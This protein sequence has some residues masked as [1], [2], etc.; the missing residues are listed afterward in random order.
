MAHAVEAA[1]D[2]MTDY[3]EIPIAPK[4]YLSDVVCIGV[5]ERPATIPRWVPPLS[6][7][8][9]E[10][11][12]RVRRVKKE[13]KIAGREDTVVALKEINLCEGSEMFPVHRGEFVMIRGPSG[14]GKTTLYAGCS[15]FLL[16]HCI[17]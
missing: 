17:S 11:V 13:Y 15:P 12:V 6:K 7:K 1:L 3:E 4:H 16:S 5:D 2:Q 14:G 10:V 9:G 8:L